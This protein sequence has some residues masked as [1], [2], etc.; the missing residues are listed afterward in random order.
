[1]TTSESRLLGLADCLRRIAGRAEALNDAYFISFC[2]SLREETD[3]LL[4]VAAR[5]AALNETT[6]GPPIY[7]LEGCEPLATAPTRPTRGEEG[8]PLELTPEEVDDM[9]DFLGQPLYRPNNPGPLAKRCPGGEPLMNLGPG[10]CCRKCGASIGEPCC[11][12]PGAETAAV[13]PDFKKLAR[14]AWTHTGWEMSADEV[15]HMARY[16]EEMYR[17]C[18]KLHACPRL[19]TTGVES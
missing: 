8:A 17:L 12:H 4:R 2:G 1:M 13:A 10:C 15:E 18:Q 5:S 6:G 14:L 11:I 7:G 3:F 16:G 9:L 19:T